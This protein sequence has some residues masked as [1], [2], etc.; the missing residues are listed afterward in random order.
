[1]IYK[2][3]TVLFNVALLLAFAGVLAIIYMSDQLPSVET[4]RDIQLQTPLMVYT[5]DHKLIG[6]FGEKRRIPIT[7]ADVPPMM[8]NAFISTEDRRFYDHS[9]V[10]FR[11]LMR[12]AHHV[13]TEGNRGQGGSTITMQL[14]RNMFL[15]PQK[16]YLRKINEILLALQ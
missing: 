3:F 6:Q 11:G 10:D 2:F 8:L 12:A 5:H 9:G 7:L 13:V 1:M 16:T 15:S 14:A 4:L